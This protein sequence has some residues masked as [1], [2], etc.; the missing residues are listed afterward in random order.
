M[1]CGSGFDDEVRRREGAPSCLRVRAALFSPARNSP[2]GVHS[3]KCAPIGLSALAPCLFAIR[4]PRHWMPRATKCSLMHG[5]SGHRGGVLVV[6]VRSYWSPQDAVGATCGRLGPIPQ[7]AFCH[8]KAR[9]FNVRLAKKATEDYSLRTTRYFARA[10]G[11][12]LGSATLAGRRRA[13]GPR[14]P[15]AAS[16]A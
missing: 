9:L 7:S 11:S 10:S 1:P 3:P 5:N 4:F 15:T 2:I 6:R 13:S 16:T 8:L 12:C 14:R